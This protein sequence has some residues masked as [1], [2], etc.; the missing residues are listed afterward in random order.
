MSRILDY[1]LGR[2]QQNEPQPQNV[3]EVYPVDDSNTTTN[4]SIVGHIR[5]GLRMAYSRI[6]GNGTPIAQVDDNIYPI[7]YISSG[8]ISDEQI[9]R[10]R[11][12]KDIDS[13]KNF[14]E[15]KLERGIGVEAIT[16]EK[17]TNL[18]KD[19]QINVPRKLEEKLNSALEASRNTRAPI[20]PAIINPN[21][22]T[23]R[24]SSSQLENKNSLEK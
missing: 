14:V 13:V 24:P 8:N 6:F 15:F 19:V 20:N 23:R 18:V 4:T 1:L 7:N 22:Q 16:L 2:N 17:Y 3:E 5:N 11:E 21:T 10:N 12:Q 9:S